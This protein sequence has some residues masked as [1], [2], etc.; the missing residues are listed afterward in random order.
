MTMIVGPEGGIG[1]VMLISFAGGNAIGTPTIMPLLPLALPWPV[2]F[3]TFLR[4]E[5]VNLQISDELSILRTNT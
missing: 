2:V 3:D 1:I 5:S 4:E